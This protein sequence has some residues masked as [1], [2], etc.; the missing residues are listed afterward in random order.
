MHRHFHKAQTD[1]RTSHFMRDS[2]KTVR[3][4]PRNA[5]RPCVPGRCPPRNGAETGS[6]GRSLPPSPGTDRGSPGPWGPISRNQSPEQ[7]ALSP[8]L[9]QD[10]RGVIHWRG[11]W[12]SAQGLWQQCTG[13][14]APGTSH[15]EG[16]SQGPQEALAQKQ[17]PG[18]RQGRPRGNGGQQGP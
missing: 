18:T 11:L 1:C 8:R 16:A 4:I 13:C 15:A 2:G 14:V 10:L 7:I 5:R 17:R 3:H 12:G 6:R 9:P